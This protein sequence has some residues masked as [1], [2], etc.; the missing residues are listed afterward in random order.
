M[1]SAVLV[2]FGKFKSTHIFIV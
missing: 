1:I 2:S